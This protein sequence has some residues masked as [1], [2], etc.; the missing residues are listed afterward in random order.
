MVALP[1]SVMPPKVTGAANVACSQTPSGARPHPPL[2]SEIT[3]VV[4][5]L[6]PVDHARSSLSFLAHT[7]GAAQAASSFRVLGNDQACVGNA[8]SIWQ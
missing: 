2:E 6:P 1:S 5:S 7:E 8:W 3:A 4:C